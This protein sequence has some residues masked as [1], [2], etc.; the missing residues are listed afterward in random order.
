MKLKL[1]FLIFSLLYSTV[2]AKMKILGKSR[3][4]EAQ[5]KT[6]LVKKNP[7]VNKKYLHC[8]KYYLSE[9]QKEGIR[10]DLAFCQSLHE[11]NFFKFG[12]DVIPQQNNFAGIGTIGGGEKGIYFKTPQEGIRAQIQH[13]KGYAT[14]KPLVYPC[15]DPRYQLIK[16]HGCAPHIEDLSGKWASPGYDTKK[17]KTLNQAFRKHDTYGHKIIN[18]YNEIKKTKPTVK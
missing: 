7:K 1:F 15:V 18:L 17:Y 13:L 2:I 3:C 5:M 4:T 11:T 16:P 6:Y 9:G 10:G 12:G 8:V 14:K